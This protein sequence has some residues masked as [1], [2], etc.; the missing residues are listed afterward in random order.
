M[1]INKVVN[2]RATTHGAMRNSI[3]YIL[4]DDS[5]E[6]DL[7]EITGPYDAETINYDEVYKKLQN[8]EFTLFNSVEESDPSKALKLSNTKVTFIQ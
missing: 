7:L 5:L 1:A 3:E 4:R 8:G 2:N 6:Q